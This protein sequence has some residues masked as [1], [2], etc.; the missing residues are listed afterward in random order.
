MKKN[1][2][3]SNELNDYKSSR[4]YFT[5][6]GEKY[7]DKWFLQKAENPYK[8]SDM[9]GLELDSIDTKIQLIFV[10][11]SI[12]YFKHG[13]LELN[14]NFWNEG[15]YLTIREILNR[16]SNIHRSVKEKYN[17]YLG[18]SQIVADELIL[19]K[20]NKELELKKSIEENFEK[21]YI[22]KENSI[23]IIIDK[24]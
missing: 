7:L 5:V 17:N 4:N 18:I 16:N 2:Y 22:D 13:L 20:E 19:E 1:D 6:W 9:F 3:N 23:S 10:H 24:I 8:L 11:I 14:K 21:H 12:D 15:K